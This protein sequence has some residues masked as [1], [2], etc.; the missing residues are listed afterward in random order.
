MNLAVVTLL[1][2]IA[3]LMI[4]LGLPLAWARCAGRTV[5]GLL[6]ALATCVLPVGL[7]GLTLL[8]RRLSAADRRHVAPGRGL[9]HRP[10]GDAEPS[11]RCLR[12]ARGGRGGPEPSSHLHRAWLRG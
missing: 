1:G 9:G 2:D 7:L 5:H 10:P 6:N 11:R 3:G 8:T 4:F 12:A